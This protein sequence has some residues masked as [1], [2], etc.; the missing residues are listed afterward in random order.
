M[1]RSV[2]LVSVISAGLCAFAMPSRAEDAVERAE[3]RGTAL[4]WYDRAAWVTS[5]D[6][7][8]RLPVER[9]AEIGGWI[10]T[11]AA[12][13]YH[14]DYLGQGEAAERVVYS[15]DVEG[16]TVRNAVIFPKGSEPMLGQT[17]RAMARA[18]GI[19]RRAIEQRSDWTSCAP[20]P[21]NTIV[22]PPEG[23]VIPVYF[24]TPQTQ[25]DSIPFGGHYEIDV[26]ERGKV[27]AQRAFSRSCI[28]VPANA[29][30]TD[31]NVADAYLTHVLDAHP[32]EIHVFQQY[33][34]G[35]PLMVATAPQS[36]WRVENGQIEPV[37]ESGRE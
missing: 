29:G 25:T 13:G 28:E 21:F 33:G 32:T 31:G 35:V 34:L 14:V 8:A 19:A 6:L 17:A 18:L 26:D 37:V 3:M 7:Q 24:L 4:F 5:D 20:A 23:G 15:A 2:A 11:P 30:E 27:G 22:L 36:I 10:V 16:R 9:Y 12:G 1:G